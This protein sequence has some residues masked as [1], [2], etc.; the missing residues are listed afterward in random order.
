[1][2]PSTH[3]SNRPWFFSPWVT[4]PVRFMYLGRERRALLLEASVFLIAARLGLLVV[5]FR[6]IAATVGRCVPPHHPNP[7]ANAQK[8]CIEVADTA[9]RVRWAIRLAV[10]KLPLEFVC[11]PQALAAS[12]MLR[13]RKLKAVLHLGIKVSPNAPMQA[14]AWSD[15]AGIPVT[16]YPVSVDFG[17]VAKFL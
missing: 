13:R 14:H 8:P 3:N 6:R 9:A 15:C 4:W 16:G 7:C 12:W 5:P 17:E 11:L 10:R 2:L 1:M